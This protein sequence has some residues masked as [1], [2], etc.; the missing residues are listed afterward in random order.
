MKLSGCRSLRIGVESGSAA[1]LQLMGKQVDQEQMVKAFRWI[2]EAGIG[3]FAY[4][5]IGYL[6]ET[7][8]TIRQTLSL[9]RKLSPDLLMY[10]IATPFPGTRLFNQAVQAGLV[11]PDYWDNFIQ[12]ENYPRVP[13]LCKDA[14]RWASR[15]YRDFFFSP[16]V[17]CGKLL[18]LRPNTLV[19][20]LRALKGLIGL[21][22]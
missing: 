14:E 18:E 17:I 11:E 12:D 2:K 3:T 20:Y 15:A 8:E 13:Y 22:R 21:K 16:R 6:N 7:E 10:N 9:V 5:I 1:M 19:N 4:L